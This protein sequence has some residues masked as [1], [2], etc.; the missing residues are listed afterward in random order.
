MTHISTKTIDKIISWAIREEDI[1]GVILIGFP[2]HE[3]HQ[4]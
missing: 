3:F 1:Q 2:D 4:L